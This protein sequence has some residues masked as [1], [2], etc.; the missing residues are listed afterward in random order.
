[1]ET[2]LIFTAM[3]KHLFYFRMNISQFILHKG[4][5][6]LNSF[7]NFEYFMLDTVE[8]EMII[9]ANNELVK[10]SHELWV[11]G[12]ISEGVLEEILL[13][14]KMHKPISYFSV[15]NRTGIKPIPLEQ[16]EWEDTAKDRQIQL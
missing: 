11:F 10:L 4:H 12:P 15:H 3:S 2:K 16:V 1:M 7:M 9:H 6:P 5:V 13:S 14:K 8:R